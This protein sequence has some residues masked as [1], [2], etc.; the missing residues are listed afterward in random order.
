MNLPDPTGPHNSNS[1]VGLIVPV[2]CGFI[3][4]FQSA[5]SVSNVVRY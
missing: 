3:S 2:D 4:Y 5:R 1:Q